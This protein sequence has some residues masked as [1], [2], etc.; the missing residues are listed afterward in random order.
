METIPRFQIPS[1]VAPFRHSLPLALSTRN[2]FSVDPPPIPSF[3]K[4]FLF[5]RL[6]NLLWKCPSEPNRLLW[7]PY[8]FARDSKQLVLENLSHAV[9]K[10]GCRLATDSYPGTCC[11]YSKTRCRIRQKTHCWGLRKHLLGTSK[12]C[13]WTS[14]TRWGKTLEIHCGRP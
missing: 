13:C 2:S 7:V 1:E 4:H 12:T 8:S 3:C 10:I 9:L 6:S 14:W 5:Q 11:G